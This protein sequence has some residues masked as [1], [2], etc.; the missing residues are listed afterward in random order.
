MAASAA[1]ADD[2]WRRATFV[3]I[4]WVSSWLNSGYTTFGVT[5]ILKGEKLAEFPGDAYFASAKLAKGTYEALEI[6]RDHPAPGVEPRVV[7]FFKNGVDR[8]GFVG[9]AYDEVH[10]MPATPRVLKRLEAFQ[11]K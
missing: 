2:L 9:P 1:N 6:W 4:G 3:G 8:P 5:R 11:S 7:I 10:T